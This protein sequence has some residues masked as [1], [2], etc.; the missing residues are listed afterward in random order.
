MVNDQR[1][2]LFNE[3]WAVE[4]DQ[5]FKFK[6]SLLLRAEHAFYHELVKRERQLAE[7]PAE[8]RALDKTVRSALY[9]KTKNMKDYRPDY[10]HLNRKT[11]LGLHGEFDENNKHEESEARLRAIS[12]DAGCG[13]ART[14]YFRVRAHL[15][16]KKLALFDLLIKD[17]SK[18]SYYEISDRGRAMVDRV[19]AYVKEC[20]DRMKAGQMPPA[21]VDENLLIKWF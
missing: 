20:L 6:Q 12:D 11:M 3:K 16:N 7:F 2:V 15:D 17:A 13:S 14:Y 18:Y 21:E 9:G 19:A 4:L 1:Y 5:Y 10:F 8:D